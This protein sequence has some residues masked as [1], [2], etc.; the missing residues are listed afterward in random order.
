MS[1]RLTRLLQNGALI[2]G[3]LLLGGVCL[4]GVFRVL[5]V[6]ADRA[7]RVEDLQL[8]A[9][10]SGELETVQG[11]TGRSG[12]IPLAQRVRPS[13]NPKLIYELAPNLRVVADTGQVYTTNALGFRGPAVE[14]ERPPRTRRILGLGDSVMYGAGV[15]DDDIF[16]TGLSRSLSEAYPHEAWEVINTAV[17][18]YNTTMEVETL[19]TKGLVLEPDLVVIM[20]VG[21]DFGLPNFIRRPVDPFAVESFA[22]Q[23]IKSRLRQVAPQRLMKA[24]ISEQGEWFERDPHKVPAEYRDMV[25]VEAYRNAMRRLKSL[26]DEHGFE[27]V[28]VRVGAEANVS[29]VCRELSLRCHSFQPA[30]GRYMKQHGIKR[31]RGSVLSVSDRDPHP[32]AIGHALYAQ[33]LLGFLQASGVLDRVRA[34]ALVTTPPGDQSR[35]LGSDP[36]E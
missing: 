36:R 24:P 11:I 31:W 32:S 8:R 28:V 26:A 27:V 18:G 9:E 15:S 29:E 14:V 4:E 16:L 23:A 34:R 25:G 2:V 12:R 17:P 3:S 7:G 21:N 6:R 33:D 5:A 30:I 35:E 13:P 20:F 22:W 19:A 1:P 10:G